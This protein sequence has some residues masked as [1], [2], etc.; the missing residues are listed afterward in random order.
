MHYD[1]DH[2]TKTLREVNSNSTKLNDMRQK[3]EDPK[4]CFGSELIDL[5]AINDSKIIFILLFAQQKLSLDICHH[6]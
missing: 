4:Q 1:H 5:L 6:R 3:T 2:R